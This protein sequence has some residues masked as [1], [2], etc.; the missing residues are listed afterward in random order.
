MTILSITIEINLFEIDF[1]NA[2]FNMVTGKFFI[3]RKLNK[4]PYYI[5][6]KSNHPPTMIKD[7]LNVMNRRVL[8]LCCNEE[9]YEKAKLLNESAF[10]ES[11]YK[12]TMTYTKITTTNNRN[13]AHNN[14]HVTYKTYLIAK[15]LKPV[16]DRHSSS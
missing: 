1:L 4:K 16:L 6:A 12:T 11:M 2:T 9:K 10:N 14:I 15:M 7:I 13:R 8:D 3:F 5:N